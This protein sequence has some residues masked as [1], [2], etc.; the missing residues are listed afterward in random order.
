MWPRKPMWTMLVL[1]VCTLFVLTGCA[2]SDG[3]EPTSGKGSEAEGPNFS[4]GVDAKQVVA[5]YAGG[6]VTA[7]EFEKYLALQYVLNPLYRA[8]VTDPESREE[9]LRSYIAE[10]ILA[11]RAGNVDVQKEADSLF[12]AWRQAFDQA[13]GSRKAADQLL[14]RLNLTEDDVRDYL[15]RYKR[16]ETYLAG[17]VKDEDLRKRYA[18][19]QNDF[20]VAT[21][22]HILISTDGR[23]DEEAKKLAAELVRRIQRGEDMAALAKQYSDD[24]G[25]KERGGVYENARVKEWVPEFQQAVLTQAVGKVGAPVKTAYGYHVIRVEKREVLP[26]EKVHEELRVEALNEAYNRFY[27]KELPKLIREI[28]LPRAA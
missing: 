19:R 3:T 26:F 20:T 17:H 8:V 24:P 9:V 11:G 21:V 14:K 4:L 16:I 7:G 13:E 28:T 2:Q 25:S 15:V 22:R 12:Q 18:E 5:R 6:E 27:D 23:S 1:V 10:T